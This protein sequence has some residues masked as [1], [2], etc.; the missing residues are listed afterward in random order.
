MLFSYI[1]KALVKSGRPV[2]FSREIAPRICH[3]GSHPRNSPRYERRSDANLRFSPVKTHF[4]GSL[5]TKCRGLRRNFD[6]FASLKGSLYHVS[7]NWRSS[8]VGITGNAKRV[9][10]FVIPPSGVGNSNP[11]SRPSQ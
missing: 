7:C 9:V 8:P 5:A 2:S 10:I 3:E 4:F 11:E 6:S 1:G